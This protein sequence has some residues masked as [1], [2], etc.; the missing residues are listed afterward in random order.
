MLG[1]LAS[2]L[3]PETAAIYA[4]DVDAL[5]SDL[6]LDP[7]ADATDAKSA[8]AGGVSAQDPTQR[9]VRDTG[10]AFSALGQELQG[11]GDATV[12]GAFDGSQIH[13]VVSTGQ[14]ALSVTA[15]STSQS[16]DEIANTL[17]G[18]GYTRQGAVVQAAGPQAP[19]GGVADGGDGVIIVAGTAPQTS[20][21]IAE[22]SGPEDLARLLGLVDGPVE[23][24]SSGSRCISGLVVG[25]AADSS[26]GSVV[27]EVS[28]DASAGSIDRKAIDATDPS[29]EFTQPRIEGSRL[30][31]D[32]SGPAPGVSAPT[33][34]EGMLDTFQ[35]YSAYNCG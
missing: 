15:I 9:L 17:V 23:L 5:R 27:V 12:V 32:Y 35:A 7:G 26:S 6:G 1:L 2:H 16:F 19:V 25:Q 21:A 20:A 14:G 13:G 34:L 30:S 22:R 33:P 8:F 24:A 31:F 18:Q 29:F 11:A 28:G 10:I 3:P 4:V